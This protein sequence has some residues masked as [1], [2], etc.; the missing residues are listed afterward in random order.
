M[1]VYGFQPH[2]QS[3]DVGICS[4][5]G[6][7]VAYKSASVINLISQRCFEKII[8]GVYKAIKGD[9]GKGGRPK[10]MSEAQSQYAGRLVVDNLFMSTALIKRR[11]AGRIGLEF[12]S[13]WRICENL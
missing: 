2:I 11:E 3:P 6:N 8:Y 5:Q 9:W 10:I 1:Y 4:H 12:V 7:N 13:V